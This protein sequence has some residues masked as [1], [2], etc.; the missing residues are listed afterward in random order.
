MSARTRLTAGAA[1]LGAALLG[2]LLGGCSSQTGR[3]VYL[4]G[5]EPRGIDEV[6]SDAPRSLTLTPVLREEPPRAY[7]VLASVEAWA[8]T[9]IGRGLEGAQDLALRRLRARAAETGADALLLVDQRVI[10]LPSASVDSPTFVI[11][12]DAS[13]DRLRPG[14]G[15]TVERARYRVTLVGRAIVFDDA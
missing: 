8:D 7:A 9:Q 11:G 2:P 6:A 12:D 5:A 15:G 3:T 13:R 4:P 14:G 10:E 1:L